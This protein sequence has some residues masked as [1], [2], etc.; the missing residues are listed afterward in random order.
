MLLFGN[1]ILQHVHGEIYYRNARLLTHTCMHARTHARTHA[2]T[3]THLVVSESVFGYC[4][5][6]VNYGQG[7]GHCSQ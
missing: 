1:T 6:L 2:H 3:H 7:I 4:Y 5:F